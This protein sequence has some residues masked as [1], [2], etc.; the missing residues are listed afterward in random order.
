MCV[1]CF[2]SVVV[3]YKQMEDENSSLLWLLLAWMWKLS[4]AS[5][6]VSRS[7]PSVRIQFYF[8]K[9]ALNTPLFVTVAGKRSFL[10]RRAHQH[11]CAAIGSAPHWLTMK[12]KPGI[13]ECKCQLEKKG[14]KGYLP[15]I[16]SSE[17]T[18]NSAYY[19]RHMWN[20]HLPCTNIWSHHVCN[21]ILILILA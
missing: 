12:Q 16:Q 5:G 6:A 10:W 13:T 14:N 19:Y 7:S 2:I 3:Q 18:A 15:K 11:R 4:E 21:S 8:C 9:W 20:P 17:P 1:L